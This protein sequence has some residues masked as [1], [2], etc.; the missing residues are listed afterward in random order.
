LLL[1][2]I[3]LF[4]LF[5]GC[6]GGLKSQD[7]FSIATDVSV[8][9]N[10]TSGQ[11]FFA[12]GQTVQGNFYLNK[13]Q[14][15]YAL[16]CY[17]IKGKSRNPLT[18]VARD[19][20]TLP[21]TVDFNTTSTQR[22]RQISTGFKQYLKG[23]YDNEQSWNLYG[24]AGFGLLFGR[25]ENKYSQSIDATRYIVPQKAIAGTGDFKRLTFDL[26][27][28]AE[29][30]IGSSIYVYAEARTWIQASDYPSPYLY[31]NN[32]PRTASLSTGMRI[33]ID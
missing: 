4:I 8:I 7:A 33:L 12:I 10:F 2:K 30:M 11:R 29:M 27:L 26:G 16:L 18:A 24:M 13:K 20:F 5:I 23:T 25:V 3:I 15:I 19:P 32:L 6:Y 14:S 1:K 17:Y 22:F 31:N 9:G 21:Q 28:G